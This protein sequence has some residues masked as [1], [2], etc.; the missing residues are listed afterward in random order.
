MER[1]YD[2]TAGQVLVNGRDMKDFKIS[3]LRRCIGYVGTGAT[4][5]WRPVGG[6]NPGDFKGFQHKSH[7]VKL[8]RPK[9]RVFHP[10]WW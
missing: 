6:L 3:A 1:F 2:P 5:G 10:K 7:L 8:Q 4:P 9:T